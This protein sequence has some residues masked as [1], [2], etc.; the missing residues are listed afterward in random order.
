V[1]KYFLSISK[2]GLYFVNYLYTIQSNEILGRN[3]QIRQAF[4]KQ[5]AI[6]LSEKTPSELE[7]YGI[8]NFQTIFAKKQNGR[9]KKQETRETRA[10]ALVRTPCSICPIVLCFLEHVNIAHNPWAMQKMITVRSSGAAPA[11]NSS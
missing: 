3:Q 7:S 9:N 5:I 2:Y 4:I 10:C 11:G 6:T 1:E 8:F